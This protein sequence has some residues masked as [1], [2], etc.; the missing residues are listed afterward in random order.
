MPSDGEANAPGA[1]QPL[2]RSARR[3]PSAG[4]PAVT[5]T[6][7]RAEPARAAGPRSGG[8]SDQR[9]PVEQ[10][11]RSRQGV[12]EEADGE[13]DR[14]PRCSR[15]PERRGNPSAS[16]QGAPLPQEEP[17]TPISQAQQAAPVAATPRSGRGSTRGR[18]GGRGARGGQRSAGQAVRGNPR[19]LPSPIWL[20]E[21]AERVTRLSFAIRGGRGGTT[22]QAMRIG[23]TNAERSGDEYVPSDLRQPDNLDSP[24]A[25]A[26]EDQAQQQERDSRRRHNRRPQPPPDQALSASQQA[27]R[28]DLFEIATSWDSSTLTST[29]HLLIVRRLPPQILSDYSTCML[30]ALLRISKLPNCAGAWRVLMF[31][32]RLTL[33]LSRRSSSKWKVLREQMHLFRCG[34]WNQLYSDYV[35][36]LHQAEPP[37][38][39][40]DPLGISSHVEGLVKRGNLRKALAAL[41]PSPAAPPTIATL[42]QLELKHP[43]PQVELPDWVHTYTKPT[44]FSCTAEIFSD[45]LGDCPN[46]VG[47]GPSRSTFEHYRDPALSNIEVLGHLHS[48]VT[49]LLSTNLSTEVAAL[50]SPSRLIAFAKPGGRLRPIAIGESLLR[51]AA[52][53]ALSELQ[54]ETRRFFLP[55]QFGVAVPGGAEF[56]I[57]AV[58]DLT[59]SQPSS[60]VLQLDIENAFN[61]VERKAF[62]NALANTPLAPLIPFTRS[63]YATPSQLLTDPRLSTTALTSGRGVRQGDPLGPLLFAASIQQHLRRTAA[64]HPEVTILAY[65]D[66]IT[67]VGPATATLG[68]LKLLTPLLA[69]DGLT[70]NLRKSSSWSTTPLEGDELPEGLPLTH[71]GVRVLGSP[72]GSQRFCADLVRSTLTDAAAP[73]GSLA[74]IHP[75]SVTIQDMEGR[76]PPLALQYLREE[77]ETPSQD[78]LQRALS[79]EVHAAKADTLTEE[80]R[81]IRSAPEM[82]HT[83]RL[84]SLRGE[85][86]GAWLQA[87]PLTPDLCFSLGQFRTALAFRMGIRQNVPTVCEC[88]ELVA[89]CS[90]PNHLLR[91]STGPDRT[92]THNQLAFAVAKMAREAQL[93]VYLE[94][95]MYSPP[96]DPKKADVIVRDPDSGE[97]WITD[98][99]ITDHVLQNRDPTARK[100]PGWAAREA[101][102]RKERDYYR[103]TEHVVFCALAVETYGANA[104]PTTAFLKLLATAAARNR[105][106]A[107]PLVKSAKKM[108]CHFSQRWSVALQRSQANTLHT[109]ARAGIEAAHPQMAA[110]PWPLHLGDIL[111]TLED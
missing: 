111:H 69:Q 17:T 47:A 63:F 79:Q 84:V 88:E 15:G 41:S 76:L 100:P 54:E 98:T 39:Q 97:T 94:N 70:R 46:G 8:G 86:A 82:G 104:P 7:P 81:S 9:T 52:K 1:P 66:D 108:A 23:D 16:A 30:A 80:S 60:L 92:R 5:R 3:P 21:P 85:G 96:D 35:G 75:H 90:L 22:A 77:Q 4:A 24:L 61:S 93:V 74:S 27:S 48:A 59:T 56:V 53:V 34:H 106:R 65:A 40:N 62:F 71:E 32:P 78:H 103:N 49:H 83:L 73:L 13:R 102:K 87:L 45:I 36:S 68:A 31:L 37:Q 38:H 55:Q 14:S 99:T 110:D 12:Q 67:M 18:G 20:G 10:Q 95:A 28:E 11:V 72:V 101:Q 26:G 44:Q 50:L 109:K 6:C 19:Q 107:N 33:R 25:E 57:H 105:F 89:D 2:R 43:Q 29:T 42:Q 51:L 64:E 91:C 58:R